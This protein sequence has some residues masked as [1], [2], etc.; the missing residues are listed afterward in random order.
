MVRIHQLWK[1]SHLLRGVKGL[2]Y[3]GLFPDFLHYEDKQ[4]HGICKLPIH[5]LFKPFWGYLQSLI[6]CRCCVNTCSTIFYKKKYYLYSIQMQFLRILLIHSW[7]N[8]WTQN[9][10]SS[11]EDLLFLPGYLLPPSLA[12]GVTENAPEFHISHAPHLLFCACTLGSIEFWKRI[13][14]NYVQDTPAAICR[15]SIFAIVLEFKNQNMSSSF[16]LYKPGHLLCKM[17]GL[18]TVCS[19]ELCFIIIDAVDDDVVL[20]DPS[21]QLSSELADNQRIWKQATSIFK[22][23]L[24][25]LYFKPVIDFIRL[26]RL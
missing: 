26:G 6:K 18:G 25:Q 9:K 20:N 10:F 14:S 15:L 7:L 3:P 11:S 8:S 2:G 23:C 21:T 19:F 17:E 1:S 16:H 13:W 12:S 4:C 5:T 22:K 24:G